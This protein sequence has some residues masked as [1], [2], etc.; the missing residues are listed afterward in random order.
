VRTAIWSTRLLARQDVSLCPCW[1]HL[2]NLGIASRHSIFENLTTVA[3]RGQVE[4]EEVR[5]I[6]RI[7]CRR[8]GERRGQASKTAP[9]SASRKLVVREVVRPVATPCSDKGCDVGSILAPQPISDSR[10]KPPRPLNKGSAAFSCPV[11]TERAGE[12]TGRPFG[13]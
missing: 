5:A 6:A 4:T 11:V 8:A 1:S 10:K 13:R 7:A 12:G 3:R 2:R 9:K